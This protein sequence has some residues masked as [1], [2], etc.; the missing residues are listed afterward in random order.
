VRIAIAT[1]ES[2]PVP[3]ADAELL[4]PE[5]RDRGAEPELVAWSDPQ[6]DW[7]AYDLVW[8]SSTW[9]YHERLEQFRA[10]LR[11]VGSVTRMEN[12]R[13]LIDWNLDKGYL[14]ELAEA[15]VPT[16]PTIWTMPRADD[17]AAEVAAQGW[18]ELVVKPTVDLGAFNLVRAKPEEAAA[19]VERIDAPAMVQPFLPSLAEEGELSLV[20]VRGELSHVVRKTPAAGDFRVQSQYGGTYTPAELVPGAEEIGRT[21]FDA[22][23]AHAAAGD[24]PPLYARVDLVRDEDGGLCLIELE[25]IEPALFLAEAGEAAVTRFAAEILAAAG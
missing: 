7:A 10:W 24:R 12:P 11:A 6:A 8:V 5:L 14:R 18:S 23:S 16:V 25:L 20:Y 21:T 13:E 1:C 17:L 4:L 2:P 22:L 9:D 3:D 15:G 19:A